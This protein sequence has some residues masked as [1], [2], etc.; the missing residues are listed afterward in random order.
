MLN[1]MLPVVLSFFVI[2]VIAQ[3]L[4][5][6]DDYPV[7]VYTGSVATLQVKTEDEK[8]REVLQNAINQKINFA[9]QYVVFHYSCGGGCITGGILDVASG[10]VVTDFPDN[11]VAGDSPETFK[12]NYRKDSRLII[13]EGMSAHDNSFRK[14]YYHLLD[15]KLE[16]IGH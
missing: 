16:L 5:C 15:G 12:S 1:K 7:D 13:F 10:K 14:E 8:Y 2:A 9:G 4:P 3:E 11:Y 6:F